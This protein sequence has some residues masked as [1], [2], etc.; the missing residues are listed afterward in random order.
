MVFTQ[1]FEQKR[2]M[3]TKQTRL[4]VDINFNTKDTIY[5]NMFE[6]Y[7]LTALKFGIYVRQLLMYNKRVSWRLLFSKVSLLLFVIESSFPLC[8]VIYMYV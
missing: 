3:K 2:T 8:H 5:R 1:L 7:M 6:T 4:L